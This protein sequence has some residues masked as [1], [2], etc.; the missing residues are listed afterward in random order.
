[1]QITWKYI[2]EI[3]VQNALIQTVVKLPTQNQ[4]GKLYETSIIAS[5]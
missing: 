1:M 4:L 5:S 3:F 2:F